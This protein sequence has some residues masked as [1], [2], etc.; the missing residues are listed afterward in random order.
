[1]GFAYYAIHRKSRAALKNSVL[2]FS[3]LRIDKPKG[4]TPR[5]FASRQNF[6]NIYKAKIYFLT[7]TPKKPL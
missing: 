3:I 6:N 5:R 2:L 1:M 7:E 4:G